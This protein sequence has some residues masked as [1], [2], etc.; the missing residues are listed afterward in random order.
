MIEFSLPTDDNFNRDIVRASIEIRLY[1]W[2]DTH[3]VLY[4]GNIK[5]DKLIIKFDD[6]QYDTLF[7]LTWNSVSDKW[8]TPRKI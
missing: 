1:I 6:D 3:K 5:D 2:A 4:T 8:T 7:L